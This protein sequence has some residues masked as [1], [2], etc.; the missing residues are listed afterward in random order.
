MISEAN[1]VELKAYLWNEGETPSEI[2]WDGKDD[3]EAIRTG[4]CH[5]L[6][7]QKKEF[8]RMVV[9]RT[10]PGEEPY[11]FEML[12]RTFDDEH[13]GFQIIAGTDEA[14]L[15]QSYLMQR[16]FCTQ[17]V[18][19]P[20][21]LYALKPVRVHK[22]LH[23][24]ISTHLREEI[25]AFDIDLDAIEKDGLVELRVLG[26][27][28]PDG[29]RTWTL[30]TV[31]FKESPVM[32]VNSSGRDGDEYHERWISDK[33]LFIAMV[34]YLKRFT[35]S[36]EVD[37]LVSPDTIIP[38]MTEFYNATIHDHYDVVNQVEKPESR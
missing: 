28:C 16:Q 27:R 29:R 8:G 6:E 33:D 23:H 36:T 1:K 15:N 18:F 26:D 20:K 5:A 19:S 3:Y 11:V 14:D 35:T 7:D 32:V 12:F 25:T 34:L 4:L 17:K 38:A 31:W 22:Y 2:L 37:G 9:T 10:T 13:R 30:E 24:F 21:E